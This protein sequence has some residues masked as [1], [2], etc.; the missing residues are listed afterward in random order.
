MVEP[1]SDSNV[2][3]MTRSMQSH[4]ASISVAGVER[5][6][7]MVQPFDYVEVTFLACYVDR[8]LP[9]FFYIVVDISTFTRRILN[10]FQITT[11]TGVPKAPGDACGHVKASHQ[12]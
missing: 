11:H 7:L 8:P 9:K 10:T 2:T 3:T 5:H 1:L 4:S 6:S 12:W